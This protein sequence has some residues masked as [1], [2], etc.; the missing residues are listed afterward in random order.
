MEATKVK[1]YILRHECEI[2]REERGV[3][4]LVASSSEDKRFQEEKFRNAPAIFPNNSVKYDVNKVRA[5]AYAAERNLP[6]TWSQA[7]DKPCQKVLQGR[8]NVKEDK[9]TWLTWHDKDCGDLYG[10]LPLVQGMPVMLE[11]HVSRSREYSL[12][13]GK[14][15]TIHSWVLDKE[16][17]SRG[18]SGQRLLQR[19]PKVVFVKFE[20]EKWILPGCKEAGLYPIR[21][22]KRQWFLDKGRKKPQLAVS[23][24][25]VPLAPAFARTAHA[26]QGQT[27]EAAI[28][29]LQQG[30]GVST[31]ASY[32][33]VTRV[34]TRKDLL[35]YRPFKREVF[36]E[37][38]PRG[39]TLLLKKLRG[40]HIDWAD[41]AKQM[42]PRRPCCNCEVRK[43]K[44]EFAGAEWKTKGDG[45]CKQCVKEMEEAGTPYLCSRCLQWKAAQKYSEH[46]LRRGKKVCV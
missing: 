18:Q 12:L 38:A 26:A 44:E 25:Q 3:R 21:P 1:E 17:R 37:G 20:G 13:R 31:I 6:V 27:L 29:D 30:N 10:M 42:Q 22:W 23:R 5:L 2:C 24:F 28:V 7:R 16:E 11:D 8:T 4:E 32:V 14:V 34:K 39:A 15:G 40:E 35:I 36:N 19:V 43:V 9:E 46:N 45:W 33:A 41:L